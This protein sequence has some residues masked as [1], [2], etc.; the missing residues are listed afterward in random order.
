MAG[1]AEN[2]GMFPYMVDS[3]R[4]TLFSSKP[5]G[6]IAPNT[7]GWTV[8][9]LDW[10]EPENQSRRRKLNPSTGWRFLQGEGIRRGHLMGGCLEVFDW[11]RGT[12]LWPEPDTWQGA[13][14]F[15]ETSEGAPPPARVRAFQ[16]TLWQGFRAV[17]DR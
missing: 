9:F 13:I 4:K 11:L 7:D 17:P 16:G 2:C 15:L 10:A 14:L 8:E 5:I 12:D 3:V 6:T 1:F